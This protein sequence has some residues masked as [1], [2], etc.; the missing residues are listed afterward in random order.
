MF[1]QES[2]DLNCFVLFLIIAYLFNKMR[3][4]SKENKPENIPMMMSDLIDLEADMED[5]GEI[6]NFLGN[7]D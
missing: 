7:H 4:R 1:E 2:I 5:K 3:K 6:M